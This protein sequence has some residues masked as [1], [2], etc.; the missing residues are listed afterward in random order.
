M[1]LSLN[2]IALLLEEAAARPFRGTVGTLGKQRV[3]ATNKQLRRAFHRAEAS[4]QKPL[5]HDDAI[6][7]DQTLLE[8]MG[9]DL[10]ESLD[11]SDYEGATHVIDLN[12]PT[13]PEA[14][15]GRYDVL[16]DSG[17]IEHVFHIPNVLANI[18]GLVK[19][20]G[21]IIFIAPSSN[22]MD[23][24]FYMF[25]PTFFYDYYLANGFKIEAIYVVRY[26][27]SGGPWHVYDYSPAAWE[28][29]QMGGLDNRAYAV[30]VVATK[31]E[32]SRCD[33]I[34]QQGFYADTSRHYAGSRM[35][36]RQGEKAAPALT[37]SPPTATDSVYP[38]W[39]QRVRAIVRRVPGLRR[40][41]R[42]C[43]QVAF[44]FGINLH[45]GPRHSPN[46]RLHGRY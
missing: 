19:V 39:Q 45:F 9:F 40:A 6:V 7:D 43:E 13:I 11:Y 42:K 31:T 36:D 14:L 46:P 10:V 41:L 5:P 18:Y 24:G 29:F 32:Q 30:F 22:H 15:C 28:K 20:G 17:T 3:F 34:P 1:G 12:Q 35:A 23:H 38:L 33:M 26:H 44:R 16:L 4:P 21:R 2:A 27:P 25:S 37:S 8:A